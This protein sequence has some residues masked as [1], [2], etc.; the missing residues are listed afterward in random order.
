MDMIRRFWLR[1][2]VDKR[3]RDS[4]PETNGLDQMDQ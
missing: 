3:V 1:L 4:V 2:P